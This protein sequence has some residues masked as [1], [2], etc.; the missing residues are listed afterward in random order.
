MKSIDVVNAV[1]AKN[2]NLDIKTVA[3]VNKY[4]WKVIR[5]KI[6]N[7]EEPAICVKGLLTFTASRYNVNRLIYQTIHNIRITR[8]SVKFGEVKKNSMLEKHYIH[9]RLLLNQRNKIAKQ[10]YDEHNQRLLK[11]DTTGTS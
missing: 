11:A 4:Y 3:T 8:K 1:I 9:L 6:S 5:R 2:K 7:L 10:Y